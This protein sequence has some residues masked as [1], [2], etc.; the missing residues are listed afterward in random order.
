MIKTLFYYTRPIVFFLTFILSGCGVWNDFTTYFN[1]YYNAKDKFDAAE[2]AIKLQR[3][4]LFEFEQPNITGNVPQLL[5]S[6]IEKSSKILQFQS[7]SS[8]VDNALMMLG[9]S[10]YYQKNY[11]KA[12]RKFQEL[13]V[14]DP[15]SNLLLESNLWIA[16]T[17]I[18]LRNYTTALELLKNVRSEALTD[19]ENEILIDAYVEEIMHLILQEKY[20]ASIT[21]MNELIENSENDEVS[22]EVMYE[23]AKLYMR[24]DDVKSA[25]AAYKKVFDY[26]PGFSIETNSKLE[27]AAAYRKLGE[28]D[29]ALILL[30]EMR[31]EN[32]YS[33]AYDKIDLETGITF[34]E[35]GR[36]SEAVDLLVKVDTAYVTSTSSGIAKFKLG[37]IFEYHYK[38]L[39]SASTYYIKSASSTAP[40]EYLKPASDKAQLFK[41]YQLMH[42]TRAEAL[43]QLSYLENP[44]SFI[45]DSIAFYSD[46]LSS[47]DQDLAADD[48][49]KSRR[50]EEQRGVSNP[51]NTQVKKTKK[52]PPVRPI[53]TIDSAKS[54][55]IKNE[56]DLANMFLNELNLLDSSYHYYKLIIDNYPNSRYYVNTLYSIGTYYSLIGKSEESD[57]IFNFIYENYKTD[58]IVNAAALQIKKPQINLNYDPAE[59]MYADA[60]NKMLAKKYGESVKNFYKLFLDYPQS[61]YAPKALYA[62]GWILE[63]ELNLLDSAAVFYDSISIKYPQ[64]Q[65]SS[66]VR[67][68]LNFYKEEMQRK[69][70]ALEDSLKQIEIKK[71]ERLRAD[72][73]KQNLNLGDK[74]NRSKK[75][76]NRTSIRE[77]ESLIDVDNKLNSNDLKENNAI[78]Q[79]IIL[80]DA[81]SDSD[82]TVPR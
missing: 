68:K 46:T 13:I 10:F 82:S 55:I 32:K 47:E 3:K 69:K 35:L 44:D 65:Y 53:I 25:V 29:S 2:E 5:N 22:A 78:N 42:K 37:E 45:Q 19:G 36:I 28:N 49:N 15:E 23:M 70:L 57:S 59:E 51:L 14:T 66:R 81:E 76:M 63:N 74:N 27:L 11:Q 31:D 48:L 41:K 33:E 20:T 16:K 6:V 34:Y 24:T 80:Q 54:I 73:L 77:E 7:G 43:K 50:D 61:P 12:L 72:S 17:Q 62:G 9:K 1:L 4:N 67:P 60:E 30:E 64:S 40:P 56:Y 38:N 21:L 71:T 26:S 18:K 79:E 52:D 58:A 8:Y 39:D 75:E